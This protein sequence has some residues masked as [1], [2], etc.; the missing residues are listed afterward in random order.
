MK[1]LLLALLFPL[2]VLACVPSGPPE[3]DVAEGISSDALAAEVITAQPLDD[4]PEQSEAPPEQPSEV[5]PLLPLD[6]EVVADPEPDQAP[7][8]LTEAIATEPAPPSSPEATACLKKNGYWVRAG[9]ANAF[10]CLKLTRDSG[11]SCRRDG[12]CQG[13]CLARSM[14]CAPY[15][16]MFGCNEI[17][18]DDGARVTLCID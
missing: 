1:R 9:R 13:V 2:F 14:T 7:E 15:I 3:A 18:Q 12:D 5:P 10:T 11:K 6:T 16:P 17:L 8:A 4:A